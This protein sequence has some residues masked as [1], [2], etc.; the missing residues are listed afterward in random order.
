MTTEQIPTA[1]IAASSLIAGFAV[2][3]YSGIRPLGGIP[4]ALGGG[5]CAQ[6]WNRRGGRGTALGLGSLYLAAFVG[7]HPL[8]RKI[9]AWPSV[10]TVSAAVG[11]AAWLAADSQ[12]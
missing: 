1:P 5:W 3:R 8:G 7:S 12:S 9:G 10:L 6:E 4:L 11:A 2:A